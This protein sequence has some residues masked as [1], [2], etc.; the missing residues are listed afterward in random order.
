MEGDSSSTELNAQIGGFFWLN[1]RSHVRDQVEPSTW[2]TSIVIWHRVGIGSLSIYSLTALGGWI[3][4]RIST[5]IYGEN[6]SEDQLRRNLTFTLGH[7]TNDE[8]VEKSS[9][10]IWLTFI[11][12]VLCNYYWSLESIYE[13]ILCV[14]IQNP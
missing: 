7:G 8:D 9:F 1:Q 11:I 6:W 12:E 4:F 2:K 5:Q 10:R 14:Y 13:S 3:D